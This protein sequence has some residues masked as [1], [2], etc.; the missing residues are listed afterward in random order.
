MYSLLSRKNELRHAFA[1]VFISINNS[2]SISI[3]LG[4]LPPGL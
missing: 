1:F 3:S 2:Y 4:M